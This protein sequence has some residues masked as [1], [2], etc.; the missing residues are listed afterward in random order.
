M[1][2]EHSTIHVSI[3]VPQEKRHNALFYISVK[4]ALFEASKTRCTQL[5]RSLEIDQSRADASS[6]MKNALFVQEQQR[7]S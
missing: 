2:F 7:N 1:S 6:V 3:K 4:L 5:Q